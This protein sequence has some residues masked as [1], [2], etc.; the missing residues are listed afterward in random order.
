MITTLLVAIQAAAAPDR[1][2]LD[3]PDAGREPQV[4]VCTVDRFD[5]NRAGSRG[6]RSVLV[7]FGTP[8]AVYVSR[9][10]DGARTFAP[11]VLV[12]NVGSLS[13]GLRRGPRI[14]VSQRPSPSRM[15]AVV[16]AIAGEKGGGR[17][18]DLLAWRSGNDGL[19]WA[20]VGRINASPGSAR[21]GLHAMAASPGDRY[22]CAWIDLESGSP[23]IL[24]SLSTDG[25]VTWKKPVVLAAD[26]RAICPCCSPSAAF[27]TD[28]SVAVTWRGQDGGARDMVVARST[29]GGVTFSPPSKMGDGTWTIDACPMDG[30]AITSRLGRTTAVW[31]RE[32]RI[33][34]T[35]L[36]GPEIL[37][38]DGEQPWI[39]ASPTGPFVVW[40]RKRGG[41]LVLRAPG[42]DTPIEL[43]REA[44]DP[45][46]VSPSDGSGLVIAAWE[47]GEASHPKIVV[48]R[49]SA[50]GEDR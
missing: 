10:G 16:T 1:V 19:A 23:R 21:E 33:Y 15:S 32:S 43:D 42:S 13:L 25:G 20:P 40:L 35:D 46:I 49:V 4:A 22:F 11:P 24:G 45:V 38:G 2:V 30:G 48:A 3:A 5:P 18:G 44:N 12:A 47:S 34:R 6:P 14:A 28:G 39:A 36:T 50:V 8:D 41:P 29:D 26:G 27:G 37:L 9:S 17:D 7:T 31:R